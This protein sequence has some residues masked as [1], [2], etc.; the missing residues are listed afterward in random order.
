[1]F[2]HG[3]R[4]TIK[5]QNSKGAPPCQT[6]TTHTCE[7]RSRAVSVARAFSPGR[8]ACVSGTCREAT[9]CTA[10]LDMALACVDRGIADRRPEVSRCTSGLSPHPAPS[11][12]NS[13][14]QPNYPF[15]HTT[16]ARHRLLADAARGSALLP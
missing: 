5:T 8:P 6:D 9:E 10:S 2:A 3:T 13:L 12:D 11:P 15:L 14:S 1:M 7:N 4:L 16:S